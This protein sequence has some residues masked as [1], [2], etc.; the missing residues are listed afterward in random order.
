MF[1]AAPESHRHYTP[2]PLWL[3][4][5]PPKNAMVCVHRDVADSAG[6]YSPVRII[7]HAHAPLEPAINTHGSQ[8][9]VW[10]LYDLARRSFTLA[11]EQTRTA[12]AI[13]DDMAK[14]A[15]DFGQPDTVLAAKTRLI[16][17][18][19]TPGA[20]AERLL[21]LICRHVRD[22]NMRAAQQ[23]FG[24]YDPCA[25]LRMAGERNGIFISHDMIANLLVRLRLPP[26]APEVLTAM[27]VD[28]D[29]LIAEL[30][31]NGYQGWL[32]A[33]SWVSRGF[34]ATR[35]P[36]AELRIVS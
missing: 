27:F 17:S 19:A 13:L 16:D 5:F 1:E 35:Q 32:I 11:S 21:A 29:A 18:P 20:Q 9:F 33:E 23:D 10:W 25:M 30:E 36:H 2:W 4:S 15:T 26:I 14:W 6:L 7:H 12:H 3:Y 31:Y 28:A 34:G 22:L 24:P 8:A